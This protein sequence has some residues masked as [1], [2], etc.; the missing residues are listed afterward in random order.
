M[1]SVILGE[2]IAT[3]RKK[4]G[5]TQAQLAEF[6]SISSKTVSR[7]ETGEGFPEISIFPHLS[8]VLD[9]SIDS[10]LNDEDNI[11]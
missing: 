8:K 6:L 9:V 2:R 10:L 3:L 1:D 5:Y 4:K 11:A 7:W